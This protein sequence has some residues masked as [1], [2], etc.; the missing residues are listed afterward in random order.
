M[1]KKAT[2]PCIKS[3]IEENSET[4]ASR[5]NTNLIQ[6][7]IG[8][9]ADHIE[10]LYDIDI[11]HRQYAL[12]KGLSFQRISSLNTGESFIKA[13]KLIVTHF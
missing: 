6:V 2:E 5:V 11:T 3:L 10:T 13:L 8:F 4:N 9:T 7:P 12:A 1:P